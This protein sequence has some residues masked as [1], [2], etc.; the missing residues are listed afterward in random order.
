M[1]SYV[2]KY[3][4]YHDKPVK[5]REPSSNNLWIYTAYAHKLGLKTTRHRLQNTLNSC[6]RDDVSD[7]FI[8]RLPNKPAPVISRD[9]IIGM[10]SL[11][12]NPLKYGYNMYKGFKPTRSQ[13]LKAII[14]L[15]RI[16]KEHR[17]YFWENNITEVYPLAM[18]LMPHDQYYVT[19]MLTVYDKSHFRWVMF[20]LYAL[21]TIVQNNIS[22]KNVLWLQLKDLDSK[23]WI[24]FVDR[25]K[26]F[27]EYFG[28][29]HVFNNI[30]G[31]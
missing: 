13:Y 8:N 24:K 4:G 12:F 26:N 23:F 16:R 2:C 25:E 20:Q 14:G 19:K 29:E 31:K 9:E 22:A 18:R 21:S 27:I 10:I 5:N 1:I 6:A 11:G 7:F 30:S 17:N 28:A 3:G 15:H